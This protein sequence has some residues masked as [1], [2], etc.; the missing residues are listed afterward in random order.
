MR[1]EL[2]NLHEQTQQLEQ[3]EK[4]L[5]SDCIQQ[6]SKSSLYPSICYLIFC[7]LSVN[8][9]H[10]AVDDAQRR[11]RELQ[12]EVDAKGVEL[13]KCQEECSSVIQQLVSGQQR[14]KELTIENLDMKETLK[15]SGE[16]QKELTSEVWLFHLSVI[17]CLSVCQIDII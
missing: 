3:H 6:L 15:V 7:V 5:T 2:S 1:S 14:L 4:K 12:T 9:L 11:L 16:V 17:G 10:I 13:I 8:S